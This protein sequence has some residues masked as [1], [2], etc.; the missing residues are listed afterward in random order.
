MK[1]IK[2]IIAILLAFI[3]TISPI[4]MVAASGKVANETN[5]LITVKDTYGLPG[6]TVDVDVVLENNPGI[7]GAIVTLSYDS[8]LTLTEAKSGDAFSALVMTKPG[9]MESPCKFIWD[10]Q[11][12]ASGDI[13]DGIILTLTF[14][15]SENVEIGD[16]LAVNIS[17]NNGEFVDNNLESIPVETISGTVNALGYTP[18]D[19]DGD[20]NIN[21][22]DV[23]LL[24]RYIAGG[25]DVNVE[26]AACDVNGDGSKIIIL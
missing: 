21:T 14:E 17:V 8:G 4:Q 19:L 23:V 18:G 6:S 12:I 3:L 9:K 15:I 22:T 26:E 1:E 7:L 16:T 20:G 25:Y 24:R 2:R 13:K 11:S 5:T 10:G